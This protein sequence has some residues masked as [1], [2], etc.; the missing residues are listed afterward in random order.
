MRISVRTEGAVA[1]L[2]WMDFNARCRGRRG[3]V[4]I[5]KQLGACSATWRCEHCAAEYTL[6]RNEGGGSI[7]LDIQ[8]KV[9]NV[10]SL[11]DGMDVLVHSEDCDVVHCRTKVRG[12]ASSTV[13]HDLIKLI[14]HENSKK[15]PVLEKNL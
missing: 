12:A 4:A 7:L 10:E 2:S 3:V 1:R 13:D 5:G 15:R 9:R 11:P 8:R 14:A 6:H